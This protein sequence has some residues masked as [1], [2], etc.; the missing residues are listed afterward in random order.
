VGRDREFHVPTRYGPDGPE[1]G[2][3]YPLPMQRQGKRKSRAI[4]LHP[5]WPFK[6]CFRL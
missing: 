3:E 1:H 2:V 5:F 4:P 6:A